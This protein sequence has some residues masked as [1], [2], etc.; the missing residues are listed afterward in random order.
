MGERADSEL[1]TVGI[2]G[3]GGIANAHLPA[4]R[5]LGVRVLVY[6]V[7]EGAAGLIERHGAGEAVTSLAELLERADIVDICSPTYTHRDL[8]LQAVAA[9]RPVI[10]EKPLGLDPEQAREIMSACAAAGVSL[11]PAQVVRFFP[12]YR[13]LQQQVAAGIVGTPA[14]LRFTRI[15][16]RPKREW[17]HQPALAGGIILD[18]M[19]HDL[20]MARWLAGE[21]TEVFAR[22]VTRAADTGEVTA[23]QVVMRHASGAISS[24]FG[25]W[26][27]AGTSFRTAFSV[28][29]T[30]GYLRHDSADNR[31]VRVDAPAPGQPRG[32]LLP[33]NL[34]RSPFHDQLGE[35]LSAIRDGA[36]TRVSA[37]DGVQAVT[38]A[39]AASESARAGRPVRLG[40]AWTSTQPEER[41]A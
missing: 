36:P 32:G 6:S 40:D 2:I 9:R 11:F 17:F 16:E 12:E 19:I 20:D 14:V 15:A 5:D 35:F 37:F 3:A 28:A 22:S 34:G 4:W 38:I 18:Q 39:T 7:D 8:V 10:C 25:A 29:G 31:P 30:A 27:S 1:I 23:A 24:A 21:V 33:R 41:S 26:A 13:A